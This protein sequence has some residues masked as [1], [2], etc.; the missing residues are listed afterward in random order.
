MKPVAYR[1][2]PC[3]ESRLESIPVVKHDVQVSFLPMT[4]AELFHFSGFVLV[5]FLRIT[6]GFTSGAPRMIGRVGV[7]PAEK[8]E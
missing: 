7:H 2:I 6:K 1:L 5:E 4:I 3:T 8:L